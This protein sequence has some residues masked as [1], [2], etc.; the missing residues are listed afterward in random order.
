MRERLY[1]G[2]NNNEEEHHDY[3]TNYQHL[4]DDQDERETLKNSGFLKLII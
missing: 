4:Q 1:Q 3:K 2:E